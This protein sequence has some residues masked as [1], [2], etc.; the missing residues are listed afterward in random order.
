MKSMDN[1]LPQS[2]ISTIP[3][4]KPL[5]TMPLPLMLSMIMEVNI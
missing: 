1:S 4:R 3:V 2:K 5:F